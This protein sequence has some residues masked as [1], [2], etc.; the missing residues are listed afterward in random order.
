MVNKIT[1]SQQKFEYKSLENAYDKCSQ[2]ILKISQKNSV[3]YY[4]L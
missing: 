4:I 3:N 1:K 2:T